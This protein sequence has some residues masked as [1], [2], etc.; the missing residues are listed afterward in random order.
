MK[1]KYRVTKQA[2]QKHQ[3]FYTS[4][5]II[6]YI[7][8]FPFVLI[9]VLNDLFENLLNIII[10]LRMKIVCGIFKIFYKKDCKKI[11]IE[12]ESED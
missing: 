8:F 3:K 9:Q 10:P 7:I 4:L 12:G 1:Y 11:E 2:V 6:T 5:L